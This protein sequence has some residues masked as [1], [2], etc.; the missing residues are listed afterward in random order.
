MCVM[1]HHRRYYHRHRMGGRSF[2]TFQFSGLY[3]GGVVDGGFR[4]RSCIAKM[5]N[6]FCCFGR[7]LKFYDDFVNGRI[8]VY[9]F[10]V[11]VVS[12]LCMM[13]FFLCIVRNFRI[14][15]W[16]VTVNELKY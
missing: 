14:F 2:G 12:S 16:D 7:V 3:L 6:R 15:E 8:F 5:C 1:D 9:N 10:V 11:I 4:A 13:R